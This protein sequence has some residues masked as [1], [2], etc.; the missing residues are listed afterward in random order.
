M[1]PRDDLI[2]VLRELQESNKALVAEVKA[3]REYVDTVRQRQER[4]RRMAFV[5]LLTC[6][7]VMLLPVVG[8]FVVS[9]FTN[10][11]STEYWEQQAQKE[12]RRVEKIDDNLDRADKL[13]G[14]MET[15]VGR[16]EKAAPKE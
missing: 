15:L 9:F 16:W 10:S 12:Q 2:L 11:Q 8:L 4:T 13:A 6:L 7:G 5:L 3:I 14:R 1:E